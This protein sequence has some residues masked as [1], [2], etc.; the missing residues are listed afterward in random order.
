MHLL[1]QTA[2]VPVWVDT[3]TCMETFLTWCHDGA[4]LNRT[5][6]VLAVKIFTVKHTEYKEG[7]IQE[8]FDCQ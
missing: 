7:L 6:H 2:M 1:C 5:C 4:E 3:L 8:D